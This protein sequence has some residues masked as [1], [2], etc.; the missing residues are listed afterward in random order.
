MKK[1]FLCSVIATS[2]M[3]GANEEVN[4]K[5]ENCNNF[6]EKAD[7][8][9][10]MSK[11]INY[12]S[13]AAKIQLKSG[14]ALEATAYMQRY[15]LCKKSSLEYYSVK[16]T[17]LNKPIKGTLL[18]GYEFTRKGRF[19]TIESPNSLTFEDVNSCK[20][21]GSAN[22]SSN[23]ERLN[24]KK[25]KK[26]CL[27]NGQFIEFNIKGFVIEN[28]QKGVI[29]QVNYQKDALISQVPSNK[30]VELFITEST[31]INIIDSKKP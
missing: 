3:L 19:E 15:E 10:A 12:L 14:Y 24:I 17:S 2:V 5:L 29:A 13:A 27:I 21:V 4:I 26:S 16:D 8:A 22:Y 11:E 7:E 30:S 9:L 6:L 23:N 28:S 31:P 25:K 1:I 18:T 20:Y